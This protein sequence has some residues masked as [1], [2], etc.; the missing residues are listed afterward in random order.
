VT[1]PTTLSPL[2][3]PNYANCYGAAY[4]CPSYSYPYQQPY[5]QPQ[6]RFVSSPTYGPPGQV[7]VAQSYDPVP[8]SANYGTGIVVYVVGPNGT[9]A[10]SAGYVD[11]SGRWG[12][13][14]LTIPNDAPNG[15]YFIYASCYGNNYPMYDPYFSNGASYPGFYNP[16]YYGSSYDP[17]YYNPTYDQRLD[18]YAQGYDN[19]YYNNYFGN[20]NYPLGGYCTYYPQSFYVQGSNYATAYGQPTYQQPTY[21]QPASTPAP[22]TGTV[23]ATPSSSSR[24][25][26]TGSPTRKLAILATALFLGGLVLL[27]SRDVFSKRKTKT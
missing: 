19:G 8:Q 12:P 22:V 15:Q 6:G 4:N 21:A 20:Y 24:I 3:Q 2:V 26:F 11:Q 23:A 7:I 13:V 5:Y 10:Q 18:P 14:Y 27:S 17:R 1:T 25:P 9:A 16:G